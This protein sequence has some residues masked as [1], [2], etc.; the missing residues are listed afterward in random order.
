MKYPGRV[1][2]RGETNA[3]LI[4]AIQQRLQELGIAEFGDSG[5]FG[6]KTEQ[7]VK[8]FQARST[9]QEGNALLTD[10]KVGSITWAALF[11]KDQ[12]PHNTPAAARGADVL[13]EVVR[14]EIGVLE[15]PPGSNWG[16]RVQ[17]YL[18]SVGLN[19]PAPWC[20]AFLYWC[21][22]EAAQQLGRR[23]PV[24]KTGSVMAHWRN[25]PGKKIAQKDAVNNPALVRP[26]HI[27]IMDF[28]GGKGHTGLVESVEGGFL[29][30]AEGNTNEAG[31]REGVGVF[32][33]SRKIASIN[34][35]FIEYK[36]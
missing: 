21:F 4:R 27:F 3:R 19:F 2:K 24:V 29:Q 13:L 15:D 9:D 36:L 22:Q 16:P 10:G 25:T 30:V 35:G 28:G 26:G 1:V 8:L 17:E 33:R 23:N 6:P 12:V 34:K 14:R 31:G 7:A 18:A 32:R 5:V 11:G 20:A